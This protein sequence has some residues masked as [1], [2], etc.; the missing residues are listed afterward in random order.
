VSI[1]IPIVLIMVGLGL[2]A[3]EVYVVPGFNVIGI[4]G[5]LVLV[6]A[7]G[8]AFTESGFLGGIVTLVLSILSTVGLFYI[9]TQSGAW[10]RFVLSTN[11][12]RD[13]T[14]VDA[15]RDQRARYLGKSGTAVTPLRPSGVIDV[16]GE[17]IEVST[18]GEF[19]A[20]GS[21]VRVVAMDRRSYYVRLTE[22]LPEN[23]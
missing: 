11:L 22:S 18:E 8:F 19:I 23:A 15:E 6:F 10:Q 21:V 4:M 14:E 2:L 20:A 3:V 16:E 13:V 9:L 1:I 12:K 7:I 17:R 5:L